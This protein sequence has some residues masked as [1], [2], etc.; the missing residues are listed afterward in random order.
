MPFLSFRRPTSPRSLS[1][2]ATRSRPTNGTTAAAAAP[3]ALRRADDAREGYGYS[4]I[5]R[6]H[7]RNEGDHPYGTHRSMN[8]ASSAP[9][10]SHPQRER[11][12]SSP[13]RSWSPSRSRSPSPPP[14]RLP[15]LPAEL[16]AQQGENDMRISDRRDRQRRDALSTG[17]DR[18]PPEASKSPRHQ[19]RRQRQQQ[20][21]G[22]HAA[23]G[24]SH[25]HPAITRI[26]LR[27]ALALDGRL[28]ALQ[29]RGVV[30]GSGSPHELRAVLQCLFLRILLAGFELALAFVS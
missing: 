7:Y 20:Q 25:H 15:A 16:V 26:L 10:S 22:R 19:R 12:G 18:H 24:P 5:A 14:P 29:L 13:S 3:A 23:A 9:R 1:A 8:V 17:R 4:H 6:E 11:H 30:V 2:S 28:K 27:G 21:H